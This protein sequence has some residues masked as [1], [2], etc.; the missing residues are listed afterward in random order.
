MTTCRF[1][2][3]EFRVITW[4]VVLREVYCHSS[5]VF[6]ANGSAVA[7]INDVDVVIHSHDEV[8]ATS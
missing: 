7:D 8:S 6:G 2:S 1:Y 3:L 4:L 5:V